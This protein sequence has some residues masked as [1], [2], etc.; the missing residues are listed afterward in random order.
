MTIGQRLMQARKNQDLTQQQVADMCHVSR[1]TVSSWESGRTYPDIESIVRLA[2]LLDLSLDELMR[3][4]SELMQVLKH[5]EAGVRD[6]RR[7]FVVSIV[8]MMLFSA[9]YVASFLQLSG[10][11][12]GSGTKLLLLGVFLA[13]GKTAELMRKRY[14]EAKLGTMAQTELL[15]AQIGLGVGIVICGLVGWR[16]NWGENFWAF[17]PFLLGILG[18]NLAYST[19][20][21]RKN[22]A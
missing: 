5:R 6:A 2:D 4:D 18:I 15:V 21:Y 14:A 9:I 10:F 11:H 20:K 3:P 19:Q 17:S 12:L 13:Q 16:F 1:Q 8:M 7:G 22:C